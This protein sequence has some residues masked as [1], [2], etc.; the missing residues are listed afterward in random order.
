MS[1][2][3][4]AEDVAFPTIDKRATGKVFAK[5]FSDFGRKPGQINII[6][7][8]EEKILQVNRRFLNHD[9]LTDIITFQSNENQNIN[10]ELYI[11][12]ETVK[13]NAKK[14]NTPYEKE[15]KRVLVHGILHLVGLNDKSTT[16]SAAMRK[17]EDL[18]LTLFS[19]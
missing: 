19:V 17:N 7:C 13:S 4:A 14:L 8:S 18:Y 15:L 2:F 5:V 16:E 3:F 10:G 9:Y 6:F 1:F 11:S 12:V